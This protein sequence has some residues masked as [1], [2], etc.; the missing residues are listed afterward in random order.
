[1]QTYETKTGKYQ[2]CYYRGKA[3][4]WPDGEAE[5]PIDIPDPRDPANDVVVVRKNQALMTDQEKDDFKDAYTALITG[6]FMKPHVNVHENMTHRMHGR[7]SG[8]IGYQRFLPWHRAYLS[9][10]GEA[11]RQVNPNVFL[12][13]WKWTVDRQIPQWLENFTPA[14]ITN[15]AGSPIPITRDPGAS[16]FAPSLPTPAEISSISLEVAFTSFATRLEGSPF[17]AHDRVHVWVGGT[18]GDVPT[19]P[20]DPLFWLHH[21][22]VDRL[23]NE[24]QQANPGQNPVLSGPDAD[25]DPWPE[26]V[27]DVLN[28][29]SLG[30]TY[31]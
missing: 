30:Y 9:R 3:Y 13:Y 2:H 12:P 31:G 4:C 6:G 16:T 26:A 25:L 15:I 23:W 21:A 28:I 19:A 1:M 29:S 20:A 5:A 14:G 8:P 24:W 27:S 22:E 17:G 10:L 18:M 7:S 11:L